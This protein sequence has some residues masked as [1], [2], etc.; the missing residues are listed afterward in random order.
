MAT[1]SAQAQGP[2]G[3][4]SRRGP[5]PRQARCRDVTAGVPAA[6]VGNLLAARRGGAAPR[7]SGA[8]AEIA[9][10]LPGCCGLG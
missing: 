3:T 8:S 1:P 2:K 4:R 5:F 7:P 6:P 9:S 10:A